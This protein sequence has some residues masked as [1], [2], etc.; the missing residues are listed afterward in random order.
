MS[1]R[2]NKKIS[3]PLMFVE[4]DKAGNSNITGRL[5][6]LSKF[7]EVF[8]HRV[9]LLMADR[10]FIGMEWFNALNKNKIPYFIRV[11]ENTLLPWEKALSL[12]AKKFWGCPR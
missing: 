10:E 4:L 9:N 8:G 2:V 5:D 1:W 3:L 11:K 12:H 6:L 7:N